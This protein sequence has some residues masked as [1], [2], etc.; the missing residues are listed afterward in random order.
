MY[1][2]EFILLIFLSIS[3]I[4]L[5]LAGEFHFELCIFIVNELGPDILGFTWGSD[6]VHEVDS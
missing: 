2:L 5:F 3:S 6:W 1:V 4:I